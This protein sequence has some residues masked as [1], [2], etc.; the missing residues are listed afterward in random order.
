MLTSVR[1]LISEDIY[2]NEKEFFESE[3]KLE[4]H[5]QANV[6]ER[7]SHEIVHEL[8]DKRIEGEQKVIRILQE[9]LRQLTQQVELSRVR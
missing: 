3:S 9:Q 5:L 4:Q 2:K 1:S 8:T 6:T 7:D